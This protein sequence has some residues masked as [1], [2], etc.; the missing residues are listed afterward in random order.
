L[1]YR[2][3]NYRGS[4]GRGCDYCTPSGQTCGNKEVKDILGAASTVYQPGSQTPNEWALPLVYLM[5]AKSRTD[6]VIANG[7]PGSGYKDN[8]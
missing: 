3:V 4:N 2:A 6:Y 7:S 8:K 1:P 5:A